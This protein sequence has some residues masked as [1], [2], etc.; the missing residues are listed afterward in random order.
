M[1]EEEAKTKW[2]P[3]ARVG[4][5][6][7]DSQAESLADLTA[8]PVNRGSSAEDLAR[9]IGSACM[10]W[11]QNAAGDWAEQFAVFLRVG[12]PIDA[13]RL[14]RNE[15]GSTLKDA[16]D[17]VDGVLDGTQQMPSSRPSGYCGLAGR[18]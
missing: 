2:C 14:H 7:M 18:P 16:K 11:R 1:T 15:T 5:R 13:I 3:F 10:A 17:F 4:V 6:W 8:V 12:R 9:C